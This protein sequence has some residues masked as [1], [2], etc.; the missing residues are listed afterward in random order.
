MRKNI[1]LLILTAFATAAACSPEKA[2]QPAAPAPA[3]KVE[4][5]RQT[6]R[7]IIL[8]T[9][10]STV[11][12]GLLDKLIPVFQRK[13]RVIVKTVAVGTGEALEMGKRGEADVLLVHAPEAETEFVEQGL[14][15]NRRAVMHND[16]VIVGPKEDPAGIGGGKDAAAALKTIAEKRAPWI[17]RGDRSGT[18]KK[19][20]A[21]WKSAGVEPGGDW[22]IESGQGM[23]A[24]LRIAD[25]RKAYTV[26]DRGTYLSAS[27][28]TLAILVEGDE[29]LFNPYHVIEVVG[30]KVNAEGGKK[31]AQ[32]FCQPEIQAMIAAFKPHG[33]QLFIPDA[34]A[35]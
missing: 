31:L 28:L 10:T 17:S 30:D 11:D 8:A 33:Q 32:F 15:A 6:L 20:Q 18:H 29:Q 22:F 35:K 13:H 26:A 2:E 21:L 7:P 24:T 34:Q 16:F 14:G 23:G 25:E 9:T 27:N 5:I 19:E 12:S 4:P 3:K 1:S